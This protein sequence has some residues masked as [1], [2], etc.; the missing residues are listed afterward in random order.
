MLSTYCQECGAK[1]EYR[2][3]KPKFCSSCG[4]PLDP[5]SRPQDKKTTKK[6]IEESVAEE[7]VHSYQID[8]PDGT[9]VFE[10]PN[11]SSLAY[12]IEVTN[13][14]FS[15]GDLFKNVEPEEASKPKQAKKRGRPKKK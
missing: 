14:S 15:F 2:F 9:D 4:T 7:E 12:D 5:L 10:V 1:N 3:S 8:D 11:L 6:V 13:N